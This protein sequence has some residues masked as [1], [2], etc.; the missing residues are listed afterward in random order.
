M[1]EEKLDEDA[2]ARLASL[3]ELGDPGAEVAI[4]YRIKERFRYFYA[5]R[6]PT[7]GSPAAHR[8]PRPLPETC[9]AA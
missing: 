4:A 7:R 6:N 5:A 2:T 8:A 3:L 9:H 1:G